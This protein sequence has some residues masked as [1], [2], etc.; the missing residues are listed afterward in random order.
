MVLFGELTQENSQNLGGRGY[1]RV[2]LCCLDWNVVTQSL[3]TAT[4]TSQVQVILLP[5]PPVAGITA[6][7][8]FLVEMGLHYV[9][10][11]GLK[12]LTSGSHDVVQA[13]LKLLGS[14][15]PSAS[16]SQ[17]AR[18]TDGVSLLSPR[19]ECSGAISA[20]C[21]LHLLGSSDS[22]ASASQVAGITSMCHHAWPIFVF[23]VETAFHHVVQ[24]GLEF[25]TSGDPPASASQS[26]GIT[27]FRSCCPGWSVMAR[28]Q[29]TTTSASQV[30]AILLPQPPKEEVCHVGQACLELM[31]SN[32]P[33]AWASQ[34]AGI[35][36]VSHCAQPQESHS[37]AQPEV[38]WRHL[39]SLQ[40]L[41]PRFKQFS[42]LSLPSTWDYSSLQPPPPGFKQF[43]CL[44]LPSSWD[45]KHAPP[46]L[47]NFIFLVETGCLHIGQADLELSTSGNLVVPRSRE[48]TILMPNLVRTLNRHST[49]QPRT[50][51]LKRSSHL[52]LPSSWDYRHTPPRPA[53]KTFLIL[54]P[55]TGI[56][57]LDSADG[58]R[59]ALH[60]LAPHGHR[61]PPLEREHLAASQLG[62]CAPRVRQQGAGFLTFFHV[63][64]GGAAEPLGWGRREA[65]AALWGHPTGHRAAV[66]FLLILFFFFETGFRSCHPDWSVVAHL[67][68]L[69]PLPPGFKL[70]CNGK[71][72]AH[73]NLYL[74]G[75]SDSPA[76]ASQVART[77]GA[78]YYIELQTSGGR[79]PQVQWLMPVIPEIWEAMAGNHLRSEVQ[80]QPG[81]HDGISLCH[82]GWGAGGVISAHCNLCLPG[83]SD[84]PASAAGVAGITVARHHAQLI[85]VFLVGTGFHHVGQAGLEL[86]TS[87]LLLVP[88]L[89]CNGAISAHHSLR[90][91]GSSDYPAAASQT[92]SRSIA[93]CQAGVQWHDLG[94][95]QP[96]PPRF[97]QFSC[98]SLLSSWEYRWSLVLS[99][100]LECSGMILAHYN[101]RLPGSSDSHVSASISPALSE[102][103]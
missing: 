2:S 53:K 21:N 94:S 81:Q 56:H 95:L 42:C 96:P 3:L 82:P 98:L 46:C 41:P 19:L 10:Q 45:Y 73:C 85:F 84:S 40:P 55:K 70:E 48:V 67:G 99:P 35:I 34:S 80:D 61:V 43:S 52:S 27:E 24:A 102:P 101:L 18:I 63:A 8:V 93:R 50:P 36:D 97:K 66:S 16:V 86:L 87:G 92:E 59:I 9:G 54:I 38:Q 78:R 58:A 90:L 20:H 57:H 23:L 64:H 22:P 4:S 62:A 32:D 68:S 76:S 1:N 69:Q 65:V 29:L 44:S 91:L 71:I 28:S 31:S 100:R 79:A 33:P 25:L 88:R 5:Q 37:V 6:S 74:K 13:D 7:F 14:S 103:L 12:L 60:V 39:S 47:A 77:T 26:V 15:N 17:N 30:Q 49:L 75:S 89:E 11:A 51:G 83:S 72:S